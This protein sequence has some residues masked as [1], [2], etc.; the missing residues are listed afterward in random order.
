MSFC[1]DKLKG[2]QIIEK[3]SF[4]VE[5]GKHQSI[6]WRKYGLSIEIQEESFLSSTTAEVAVHVFIGGSFVFPKNFV[7]VSAVYAVSVPKSLHK[8][9]SL[10]LQH[11]IDLKTY[12]TLTKYLKFATVPITTPTPSIP[13][14][15]SIMKGGDFSNSLYGVIDQQGLCYLVCVV[16]YGQVG[17][18]DKGDGVNE[19]DEGEEDIADDD[20]GDCSMEDDQGGEGGNNEGEG[21][22]SD[23]EGSSGASESS[24]TAG[25]L[26]HAGESLMFCACLLLINII[27]RSTI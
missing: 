26:S 20:D 5:G 3:K 27:C 15:F 11:C 18:S 9:F 25:S 12:P 21:G 2:L 19:G 17:L 13:Y 1:V 10:S 14:K 7:L 4:S 16:G 24:L 23:K 6:N 22:N 8:P